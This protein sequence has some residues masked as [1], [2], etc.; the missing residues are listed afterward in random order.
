[1]RMSALTSSGSAV[2]SS[3][4]GCNPCMP[5]IDSLSLRPSKRAD[6]FNVCEKVDVTMRRC[7]FTCVLLFKVPGLTAITSR[8][9]MSGDESQPH[10]ESA[11]QG[12]LLH[13]S[14]WRCGQTG[15]MASD[16]PEEQENSRFARLCSHGLTY[17]PGL[18]AH[19]RAKP[20]ALRTTYLGGQQLLCV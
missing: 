13:T 3:F 7:Q 14:R 11:C 15:H 9:L 4:L 20:K 12:R 18:H 6:I 19:P 16:G 1:M 2:P 10:T 17:G 8:L 5:K